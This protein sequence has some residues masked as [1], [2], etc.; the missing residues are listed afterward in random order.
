MNDVTAKLA[1]D[2]LQLFYT[3]KLKPNDIL[4]YAIF[5]FKKGYFFAEIHYFHNRWHHISM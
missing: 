3:Y 4:S 5:I 2:G 1:N